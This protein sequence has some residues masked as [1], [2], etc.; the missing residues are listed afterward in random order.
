MPACPPSDK[1][2]MAFRCPRSQEPYALLVRTPSSFR[3]VSQ[4]K[5]F[6]WVTTAQLSTQEARPTHHP[7][8]HVPPVPTASPRLGPGAHALRH[9]DILLLQTPLTPGRSAAFPGKPVVFSPSGSW[10]PMKAV[11]PPIRNKCSDLPL[12]T[13]A[14]HVALEVKNPPASVRDVRGAGSVSG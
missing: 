2:A 14:S 7:R 3:R 9:L 5:V 12:C 6:S 11:I 4:E 1:I 10:T 13:L 8:S